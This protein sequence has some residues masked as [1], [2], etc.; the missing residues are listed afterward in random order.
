MTSTV[1]AQLKQFGGDLNK[2]LHNPLSSDTWSI[3]S[4]SA[5]RK[6]DPSNILTP[7]S[8]VAEHDDEKEAILQ[9]LEAKY[10]QQDF[11]P[12]LHELQ[13]HTD[14]SI[15]ALEDTADARTGVLEVTQYQHGISAFTNRSAAKLFALPTGSQRALV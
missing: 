2:A 7:A 14:F 8:L 6:A 3:T 1:F 15:Q 9:G 10:Y 13:T 12:L 5:P 4:K 11:Q